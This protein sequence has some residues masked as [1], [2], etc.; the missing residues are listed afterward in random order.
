[1]RLAGFILF[2]V[3]VAGLIG[4]SVLRRLGVTWGATISFSAG[5]LARLIASLVF[6]SIAVRA[7]ERGGVWF[8]ILALFTAVL[9]VVSLGLTGLQAWAWLK[10]HGEG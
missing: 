5:L 2:G 7:A 6:A 10:T 9:A 4:G 8:E 3:I 1:M